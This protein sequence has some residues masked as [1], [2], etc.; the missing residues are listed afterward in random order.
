MCAHWGFIFAASSERRGN[1]LDW[2]LGNTI[3]E[4]SGQSGARVFGGDVPTVD[5]LEGMEPG[6][7][8]IASMTGARSAA[9]TARRG[10]KDRSAGS[11]TAPA[12]AA[13]SQ[14]S[15]SPLGVPA[16]AADKQPVGAPDSLWGS[17]LGISAH[18]E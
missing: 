9:S 5:H 1:F 13:E 15:G 16:G 7:A 4:G 10:S 2:V 11:E 6:D 3:G 14:C 12:G 8:A 17:H 18:E